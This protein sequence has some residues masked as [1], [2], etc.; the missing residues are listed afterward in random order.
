MDDDLGIFI[1]VRISLIFCNEIIIFQVARVMLIFLCLKQSKMKL[2]KLLFL[3]T[4][5]RRELSRFWKTNLSS[6]P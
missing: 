6:G 1:V 2:K 3:Y 5:V 4:G